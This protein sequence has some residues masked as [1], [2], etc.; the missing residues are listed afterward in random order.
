MA[1]VGGSLFV[2][3]GHPLLR[4]ALAWYLVLPGRAGGARLVNLL[5][6]PHGVRTNGPL[7]RG[8]QGR[9]GGRGCLEYDGSDDYVACGTLPASAS[10]NVTYAAWIYPRSG[11]GNTFGRIFHQEDTSPGLVMGGAATSV[12]WAVAGSNVT[13]TVTANAWSHVV[14]TYDGSAQALYVNGVLAQSFSIGTTL[15]APTD[16]KIGNRGAADRGFD[17]FIDDCLLLVGRKWSEAESRQW[18]SLSRAGYPGIILRREANFSSGA[19]PLWLD[20]EG[21]IYQSVTAW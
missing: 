3:R 18:Y 21:L 1:G 15:S 14:G 7:W 20:D 12:I 2:N 8:A 6:G 13:G 4:G 5:G 16:I 11:G 10:N 9:P 19:V 17:G